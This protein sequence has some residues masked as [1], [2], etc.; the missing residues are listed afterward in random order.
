M[1]NKN[2]VMDHDSTNEKAT[3]VAGLPHRHQTLE[4]SM[5]AN[6]KLA[7]SLE[8]SLSRKPADR[9]W[10]Q[11]SEEK[12]SEKG[13]RGSELEDNMI[14]APY[15]TIRNSPR[16]HSQ[17]TARQSST[18]LADIEGVTKR[19]SVASKDA[20]TEDAE[21]QDRSSSTGIPI[22]HI[23]LPDP[24]VQSVHFVTIHAAQKKDISENNQ[25]LQQ[26][27]DEIRVQE[28]ILEDDLRIFRR[29]EHA[30]QE[31]GKKTREAES[32]YEALKNAINEA[33]L[34]REREAEKLQVAIG[35]LERVKEQYLRCK[36]MTNQVYVHARMY[37]IGT[38]EKAEALDLFLNRSDDEDSVARRSRQI[39]QDNE[40]GGIG[41]GNAATMA[42]RAL[43][44]LEKEVN[45]NKEDTFGKADEMK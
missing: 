18:A 8:R 19:V 28:Q 23:E 1:D 36:E 32:V 30:L 43:E 35:N 11:D 24:L 38:R 20:R 26:Q 17:S 41:L 6:Q 15:D 3:L 29:Q 40:E 13:E 22:E 33:R 34:I 44:D 42:V 27:R 2:I 12:D 45:L 5:A 10:D 37:W 7:S 39:K 25:T 14:G 31:L 9:I 16:G 21:V 4:P